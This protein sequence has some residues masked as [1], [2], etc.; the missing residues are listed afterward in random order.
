MLTLFIYDWR[1]LESEGGDKAYVC[2]RN[3]GGRDVL[4]DILRVE[5]SLYVARN[6]EKWALMNQ[7][8]SLESAEKYVAGP[9]FRERPE[10]LLKMTFLARSRCLGAEQRLRSIETFIDTPLRT[11]PF[12]DSDVAIA[13]GIDGPGWYRVSFERAHTTFI[14]EVYAITERV[15]VFEKINGG[16][17]VPRILVFDVSIKGAAIACVSAYSGTTSFDSSGPNALKLLARF[18][19]NVSADVVACF[20]LERLVAAL[21]HLVLRSAFSKDRI[22]VPPTFTSKDDNFY[23]RGFGV[24]PLDLSKH[25]GIEDALEDPSFHGQRSFL[26]SASSE[27]C[28]RAYRDLWLSDVFETHLR[29]CR[30]AGITPA[31]TRYPRRGQSTLLSRPLAILASSL[32]R[33]AIEDGFVYPTK[34]SAKYEDVRLIGGRVLTP[35]PGLWL[36]TF[37]LRDFR[38]AYP[39][40]AVAFNIDRVT[41][42]GDDEPAPSDCW[43]VPE[44]PS[45][46]FVGASVR[47][48][49][50][51]KVL[52][53]L[54]LARNDAAPAHRAAIKL[55][56][57]ACIGALALSHSP[58]ASPRVNVAI[59]ATLRCLLEERQLD[60]VRF[61]HRLLAAAPKILGGDTDSLIILYPTRDACDD[62]EL[63]DLFRRADAFH[64]ERLETLHGAEV[65]QWVRF[66]FERHGRALILP[67]EKKKYVGVWR[68]SLAGGGFTSWTLEMTGVQR[69][70]YPSWINGTIESFF[71]KILLDH[72]ADGAYD[73]LRQRVAEL[74]S[75][76]LPPL[77]L[78]RRVRNRSSSAA[79]ARRTA[80]FGETR[81]PVVNVVGETAPIS[82]LLAA[83][84]NLRP[85]PQYCFDALNRLFVSS[86][87]TWGPWVA[88]T[89]F[90]SAESARFREWQHKIR[91]EFEAPRQ[92][93]EEAYGPRDEGCGGCFTADAHDLNKEW[94]IREKHNVV[95]SRP[96]NGGR[97][98][99]V[100]DCL[101]PRCQLAQRFM[102]RSHRS[103]CP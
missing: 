19:Q 13:L 23:A 95:C 60:A 9:V 54:L 68:R 96:M 87:S 6:D 17:F 78:A 71:T 46:R 18:F 85:D 4:F 40:V 69:S 79:V 103:K 25:E 12:D 83:A 73:Y 72:D 10:Q 42:I 58:F 90:G 97:R 92:Y 101:N 32:C 8:T 61:T 64:R 5:Y 102:R 45:L 43:R 82:S 15:P 44:H 30:L 93:S 66:S 74:K 50:L 84:L 88:E 59:V 77:C 47:R 33:R 100:V 34:N 3:T 26:P 7:P 22:R 16:D 67:S 11:S 31:A 36:D 56:A 51:P 94:E 57:N 75:G 55:C 27:R 63:A 20:E 62:E 76:Q 1:V 14:S 41:L 28:R 21:P 89:M 35:V 38:S 37:E 80:R 52:R 99:F 65:G 39:S 49:L 86:E 70:D 91:L 53:R 48:G 2:G 81:T 24:I 98:L 29:V